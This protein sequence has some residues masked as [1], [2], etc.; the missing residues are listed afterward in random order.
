MIV[1]ASTNDFTLEIQWLLVVQ[2]IF[3]ALVGQ[4][5]RPERNPKV[6]FQMRMSLSFFVLHLTEKTD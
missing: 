5:P 4:R 2:K 6:S 3:H 1:H